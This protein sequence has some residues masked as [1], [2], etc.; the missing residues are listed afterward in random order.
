MAEVQE[1][2]N[3]QPSRVSPPTQTRR[4]SKLGFTSEKKIADD[5]FMAAAIGDTEWLRQSLRNNRGG[6]NYDKSVSYLFVKE[7]D[8]EHLY[9]DS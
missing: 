9:H 2:N 8:S 1:A 5:E 3:P 6:I 4:R 7:N